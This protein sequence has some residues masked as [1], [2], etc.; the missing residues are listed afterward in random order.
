MIFYLKND[1]YLICFYINIDIVIFLFIYIIV[2]IIY[3]VL[4]KMVLGMCFCERDLES[5]CN[6]LY[7]Y[8][9]N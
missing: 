3:S 8:F 4:E 9:C 5:K 7:W 1:R 2:F 6:V